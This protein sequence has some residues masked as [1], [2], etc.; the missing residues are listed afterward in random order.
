MPDGKQGRKPVTRDALEAKRQ[1][2]YK[3]QG[4]Y[5][6]MKQ[7]FDAFADTVADDF[8]SNMKSIISDEDLEKIEL[9]SDPVK[10]FEIFKKYE[11]EYIDDQIE[12]KKDELEAFEDKLHQ[13]QQTLA[14]LDIEAQFG[15]ENPDLD[16]EGLLNYIERDMS[17]AQKEELLEKANGDDL[18]FLNLV[19]DAFAGKDSPAGE[20][21]GEGEGKGDPRLPADLDGIAGESGNIDEEGTEE[22][23]E[24][25][26]ASVGLA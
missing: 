5:E 6:T 8:K 15:E 23:E 19:R 16:F 14:A 4:Q 20:G 2:L 13:D 25:Y 17:P 11:K 9:E 22:E 7:K 21:E 1:A 18:M 12:E 24:D 26:L 3:S 10:V